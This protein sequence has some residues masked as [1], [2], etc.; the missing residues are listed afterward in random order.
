M[1]NQSTFLKSQ[2]IDALKD[3]NVHFRAGA[4]AQKRR[5]F[6]ALQRTCGR[7]RCGR[8]NSFVRVVALKQ[9]TE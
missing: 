8:G 2:V 1:I 4:E 9:P 5:A 6:A 3:F 7:R